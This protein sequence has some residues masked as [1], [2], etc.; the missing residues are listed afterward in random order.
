M[1]NEVKK[2]EI[3]IIV[4]EKE[5]KDGSRKFT[6]FKAVMKDGSLMDARFTKG[7]NNVPNK[8]CTIV[9][10]PDNANVDKN[11]LY[12]TLWIKAV[13]EII[14]KDGTKFSEANAKELEE[15]FG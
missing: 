5:T 7:C 10:L 4:E 6:A 12:P 11:K 13:E 3:R 1:S 15:L 8:S 2:Q 9:V 14:Y